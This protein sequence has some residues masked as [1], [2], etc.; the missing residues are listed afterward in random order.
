[1]YT[2]KKR[3]RRRRRRREKKMRTEQYART[4]A[5]WSVLAKARNSVSRVESIRHTC[6][7]G[8]P[9]FWLWQGGDQTYLQQSKSKVRP[10]IIGW[11][12]VRITRSSGDRSP[13]YDEKVVLPACRRRNGCAMDDKGA[14]QVEEIRS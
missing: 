5:K 8:V 4:Q 12:V 13:R 6:E 1:M 9:T 11:L 10:R 7:K 14:V 2:K 3:S